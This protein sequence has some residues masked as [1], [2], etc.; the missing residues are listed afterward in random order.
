[1]IYLRGSKKTTYYS[2]LVRK[3]LQPQLD[4]APALAADL[5]RR[6]RVEE[7][8]VLHMDIPR[9]FGWRLLADAAAELP[10][11]ATNR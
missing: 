2:G 1:M 9:T 6:F 3:A 8:T 11:R 7:T 4:A 5:K 10:L